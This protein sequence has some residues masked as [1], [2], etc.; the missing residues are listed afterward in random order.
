MK[1]MEKKQAGLQEQVQSAQKENTEKSGQISEL[2]KLC[3]DYI[4]D[5]VLLKQ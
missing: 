4:H 2:E 1:A 3:E 5:S